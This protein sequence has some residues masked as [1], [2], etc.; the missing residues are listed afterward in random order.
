MAFGIGDGIDIR[1]T[2]STG[3]AEDGISDVENDLSDLGGEAIQTAALLGALAAQ[4]DET[5]DE[6][7]ELDRA[8]SRATRSTTAL[9]VATGIGGLTTSVTTMGSAI[10]TVA[11]PALVGMTAI[12][13]SL[14]ATASALAA[15]VGSVVGAFTLLLGAGAVTH[16]QEL[17]TAF[18]DAVSEIKALLQ[19]LGE[20]FG[21][22]LVQAVQALPQLVSNVLDA[23]GPV[24]QFRDVLVDFG[25]LA[26]QVI[27]AV[28]GVMFDLARA[29]L[30]ALRQVVQFLTQNGPGA[31]DAIM[32]TAQDLRPALMDLIDA[33]VGIA[34][35]LLS[36][37]TA[38]ATIV[39]PLVADLV[40]ALD[41]LLS[42]ARDAGMAFGQFVRS[43]SSGKRQI[44]G[45][46][47]VIR[48]LQNPFTA[49]VD[50]VR[51]LGQA[52]ERDFAGIA[53]TAN[54]TVSQLATIFNANLKPMLNALAAFWRTWG[55]EIEAVLEFVA[56]IV[57]TMLV[58]SIDSAVT[59]VT[60]LL[61]LLS[62]DIDG[63]LS[64]IRGLFERSFGRVTALFDRWASG[65]VN[66]I[67]TM[68][69]QTLPNVALSGLAH[70]LAIFEA[71]FNRI[72]N[73]VT[74]ILA[75]MQNVIANVLDQVTDA[76]I[77]AINDFL[78]GIDELAQNVEGVIG[79]NIADIGRLGG[80]AGNQFRP[81]GGFQ[82][83]S[84]P[85]NVNRLA[86]RRKRTIEVQISGGEKLETEV[87]D[88]SEETADRKL[89]EQK[90]QEKRNTG[91][92]NRP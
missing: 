11:V 28:A 36:V 14:L 41:D 23:I 16:I 21:P 13:T 31:F 80:V 26:M 38:I 59:A 46:R 88:I 52:W 47:R 15:V 9:S 61:Q 89:D 27:P 44:D 92:N 83:T 63:A 6:M 4:T 17:K 54:T 48:A 84:S 78:R 76:A 40:S 67:V 51:M 30:P 2:A 86:E 10:V 72:K 57:S 56:S 82:G 69:T 74:G 43:I 91:R 18:G 77:R 53:T 42:M 87:R 90:R 3:D 20:V 19:P 55:D 65:L 71:E 73:T 1:V 7:N 33:I 5:S 64:T 70:L 37:G 66:S 79:R 45:V 50:V 85:T 32:S 81:E 35:T 60:A 22:V 29:A 39:I 24:Q 34:P 12:M 49:I 75:G 62:G 68:F 58:Q 8:T 25:N